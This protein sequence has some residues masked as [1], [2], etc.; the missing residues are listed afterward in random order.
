M[1]IFFEGKRAGCN[2]NFS[3]YSAAAFF[4]VDPVFPVSLKAEKLTCG[5]DLKNRGS[6]VEGGDAELAFPAVMSFSNLVRAI[7]E[8]ARESKESSS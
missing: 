4:E 8:A 7:D 1:A 6:T 2:I 5:V 3:S